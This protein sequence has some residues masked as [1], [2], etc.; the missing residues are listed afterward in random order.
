MAKT[1]AFSATAALGLA[2]AAC[3]GNDTDTQDEVLTAN[4]LAT[5][6]PMA[7]TAMGGMNDSAM[8]AMPAADYVTQAAASDMF[9]IRSSELAANNA[10]SA[11]V[12]DFARMMITDH[13][14]SSN[15]LKTI[16]ASMQ[17]PLP[18][19]TTLPPDMQSRLDQLE[20]ANGAEFDRLY[21]AQQAQA[22]QQAL[23]LH[24]RYAESGDAAQLK[25]FAGQTADVVQGHLERAQQLAR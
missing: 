17:P 6:D 1:L 22:H 8:A 10:E 2:L 16:A 5:V 21:A 13:T 20:D 23:D 11:A 12:K 3:S 18:I 14:R 15:E 19:P 24:R 7:N 25:T 9:E 4:E